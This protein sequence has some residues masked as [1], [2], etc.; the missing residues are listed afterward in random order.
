[1]KA[2]EEVSRRRQSGQL[3]EQTAA[4]ARSAALKLT[5]APIFV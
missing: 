5:S 1:M 2:L 4:A 3:S